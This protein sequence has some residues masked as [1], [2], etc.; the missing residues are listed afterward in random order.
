MLS[1]QD[2]T[3]YEIFGFILMKNMLDQKEIQVM[4]SEFETGLTRAENQTERT[5]FRKQLNWWNMGPDTP[6][7]AS[8]LE[9]DKFLDIANQV[10]EGE[11][12][13]SFSSANS[14]SG[15]R[16][17]WHSDTQAKHWKGLK[18]GVYLQSLNENT[19]ALRV[20]PGSHK[21][22]LHSDFKKIRLKES[23]DFS[24]MKTDSGG[25]DVN[26]I[27]AY[28][29]RIE[30]GDV[31]MFDN[32]L[33]HG[34]YGGSEDRRLVTLGYFKN[35]KTKE[36]LASAVQAVQQEK[37]VRATFPLLAR[38]PEWTNNKGHN[39]TRQFWIDRLKYIGY[40]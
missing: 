9:Q 40:I 38:H 33:W 6:Y 26:E 1:K 4:T 8:I 18:F 14:F 15:N 5:S 7:L 13:G 23:F 11:A 10:L 21:E 31:I 20:I 22:P 32:H 25:L 35:P 16:T 2:M 37:Q 28:N 3:H 24:E 17:D 34:S 36:E 29:T 30:L 27:P 39:K 19:G 12:I